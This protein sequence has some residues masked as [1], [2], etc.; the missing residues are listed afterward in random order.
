MDWWIESAWQ[1]P[2]PDRQHGR[3]E[4]YSFFDRALLS[5]APGSHGIL[6]LPFSEAPQEPGGLSGGGFVGLELASTRADMSRAVLEGCTFEVRWFLDDLGLKRH[7]RRGALDL[8]GATGSPVWPQIL[9][10]VTGVPIVLARYPNWAALG[11]AI[12]AGWGV[13]VYPSL[14]EGIERLQPPVQRIVPDPS[15]ARL[16]GDR[17]ALYQRTAHKLTGVEHRL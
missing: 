8:G 11:A 3:K 7:A 17:L 12:L 9:A 15:L 1:S 16:Y 2:D 4:L 5:S 10:D 6:F 14:E 13:G